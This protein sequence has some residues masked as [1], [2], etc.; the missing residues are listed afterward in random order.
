MRKSTLIISI[1]VAIVLISTMVFT[2]VSC[3]DTSGGDDDTPI[4][5]DNDKKTDKD[6]D[7]DKDSG[8]TPTPTPPTPPTPGGGSGSNP[9][10]DTAGTKTTYVGPYVA[11]A[12]LIG[13]LKTSQG[14]GKY[15]TLNL[16]ADI[17]KRSAGEA[18]S[19]KK[20]LIFRT[21]VDSTKYEPI[22]FANQ[23][24]FSNYINGAVLYVKN[25]KYS[26]YD[27]ATEYSAK[28]KYYYRIGDTSTYV[29]LEINSQEEYKAAI[30]GKRTVYT[31]D[32]NKKDYVSTTTYDAANT[33]YKVATDK[34]N[35][36]YVL[37]MI[38]FKNENNSS[39][40]GEES[41]ES[42]DSNDPEGPS[43]SLLSFENEEGTLDVGASVTE[44]ELEEEH[45]YEANGNLLWAVYIVDGKMFLDKGEEEGEEDQPL[46]YFEDFDMDYVFSIATNLL[47]SLSD[48]K[49]DGQLN[50]DL[51]KMLDDLLGV[52]TINKILGLLVTFV[53]PS[54]AKLVTVTDA[55]GNQTT[56]YTLEI[57]VNSLIAQIK[58]LV[59]LVFSLGLF[60]LPFDLQLDP[61]MT[62]LN[63]V[64]PKMVVNIVGTTYKAKGETTY[65][66]Q[67]FGL[68]VTDNN[69]K[70]ETYNQLLL[71]FSLS[72]SIVY[73][74]DP[75]NLDIPDKV[76][77]AANDSIEFESFGLTNIALSLDLLLNSHG[78]L[79][80]GAVINSAAGKKILPTDTIVVDAATG[81]R[82][83]LAL[84]ADLNY[85]KKVYT[86]EDGKEKLVDN[87][88]IVLELY[89]IGEDNEGNTIVVDEEPLIAV[90][91]MNGGLYANLG[92]LLERYYSGSNIKINLEGIPDVIQYVIDLVS[93]A[94]DNVF[95]DTLK[96]DDWVTWNDLWLSKHASTPSGA[97]ES[98]SASSEGGLL[99]ASEVGVV[100][101]SSSEEESG[102]FTVSTNWVTFLKA[103]G[104]VVGL[105]DVFTMNDEKTA[106][107]IVVNTILFNGI[108]ALA[109]SLDFELPDGLIAILSINFDE[110][111]GKFDSISVSAALKAIAF[112]RPPLAPEKLQMTCPFFSKFT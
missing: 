99:T 91:Y 51:F 25:E 45:S 49:Y 10:G 71:D 55:E 27:L 102:K 69:P 44:E 46:I 75:A 30:Q 73:T 64:T 106:I 76:F 57:G 56:T 80:V 81:I 78:D 3:F 84:D 103:V 63:D 38:E 97:G 108:K 42:G 70:S 61:L 96:W 18:E 17:E 48:G 74:D 79:D 67:E 34:S 6:K 105:G 68:E 16:Y 47:E 53:F 54:S 58:G 100:A 62:F 111:T 37:K 95:I 65:V 72:D 12:Q 14:S 92:H 101:L 66:T 40:S 23:Y 32:T 26:R 4:E 98:I 60:E 82:L 88:Y 36:Q 50:G 31:Y 59:S 41:G 35:N 104:Y 77:N 107:Q 33:Y 93:N 21:N 13:G 90:Y 83:E 29:K 87:N 8:T 94:L 52:I 2:L 15:K 19:T 22:T 7:K 109:S 39:E 28:E 1:L 110:N 20:R 85:G 112:T 9:S 5:N 89:L 86:D 11:I 24:E 43:A